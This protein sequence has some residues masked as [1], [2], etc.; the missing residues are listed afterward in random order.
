MKRI[1]ILSIGLLF[2]GELEVDGLIKANSGIDANNNPITN[3]GAPITMSDAINGNILQDALRDDVNY[4]Y[5]F[6]ATKSHMSYSNWVFD[7]QEIIQGQT[8]DTWTSF[9]YNEL[10]SLYND[11]WELNKTIDLS[12]SG[13]NTTHNFTYTK[14]IFIF[15]RPIADE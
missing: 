8:I 5:K 6:Y 10:I 11:G 9:F 3:V 14:Q 1:L 13:G 15:K 2:A 4:E 7:F 12:P